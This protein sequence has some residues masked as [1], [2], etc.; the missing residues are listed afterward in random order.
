MT[1]LDSFKLNL[2]QVFSP[3][4]AKS[5]GMRFMC[6]KNEHREFRVISFQHPSSSAIWNYD[7]IPENSSH[8]VS[9]CNGVFFSSFF[10]F[11]HP[12]QTNE[13]SSL[14]LLGTVLCFVWPREQRKFYAKVKLEICPMRYPF[15]N[16]ITG[17]WFELQPCDNLRS[18][19]SATLCAPMLPFVF[20]SCFSSRT[21]VFF[22]T[23][24]H[25]VGNVE[26]TTGSLSL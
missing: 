13:H 2:R 15:S 11:S 26:T 25:S 1:Q 4:L 6:C 16:I 12:S 23:R 22:A 19:I 8:L 9:W 18:A 7:D 24:R 14:W 17:N 20:S 10:T 21:L 5:P 3:P